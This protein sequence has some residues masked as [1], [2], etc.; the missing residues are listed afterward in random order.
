MSAELF[1]RIE[2][3]AGRITLTR[4]GVLNALSHAMCRQ[5]AAALE[6]WR[7]APEVALVLID[8]EGT[9]AF[10]AGGDIAAMYHAGRAGD[11]ALGRGFFRDEYRM[12][13][14]IN[15]YPKPIVALMQGFVMGG[16]VGIGGNASHR[17]LGESAQVAMPETGIGLIPDVGGTRLLAR[18]PGRL[19]LHLGMTGARFGPDDALLAGFADHVVPEEDWP[20]LVAEL[21]ATGDA[22][23]VAQ[24]ARPRREGPL[25]HDLG[26]IG[27]AYAGTGDAGDGA[28]WLR[29]ALSGLAAA[30]GDWAEAARAAGARNSPLSMASTGWM[31]RALGPAPDIRTALAQEFR[32]TWRAAEAGDFLEGVRA[33][34]I[35]KDRSPRWRHADAMALTGAEVAAMLAPLG[36]DELTFPDHGEGGA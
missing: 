5:I 17:V 11:F 1:A 20:A 6:E 16:G 28:E 4:P 31:I 18:A 12:N 29:A 36:A 27:R 3:R 2:G 8:A 35:D 34:I 21:V 9:R 19:G 14:A 26:A 7:H 24:A 15:E 13:A 23:L 10:C 33:Q 25:A 30:S 32:W 22:G